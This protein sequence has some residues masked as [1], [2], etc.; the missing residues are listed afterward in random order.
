[1]IYLTGYPVRFTPF[2][3]KVK[4]L[5]VITARLCNGD[6]C[7]LWQEDPWRVGNKYMGRIKPRANGRNIVGQHLDVTCYVRLHTL[8]HF[9]AQNFKPVKLLGKQLPSAMILD[10]FAQLFLKLFQHSW[11]PT[12]A[13]HMVSLEVTVFFPRCT[14]QVQTMLGIIASVCTPLP[15]RT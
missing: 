9:V 7:H 2:K 1:M 13:W 6:S 8:L 14:L 12:L 15:T 10:P 5:Y 4:V 11:G 3:R